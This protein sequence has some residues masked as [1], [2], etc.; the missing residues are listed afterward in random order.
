MGKAGARRRGSPRTIELVG[1]DGFE[2]KYPKQL[3]GGMRMRA[4]LAR[5]LVMDPTIF[6]FDEP[7]GALDEIT[8]ERLNDELLAL[9][10]RK[11]FGA[12][13][14][15]HSIYRGRVPVDA[16]ARDVGPPGPH[17][18]QLRRAVRVP[19]L[20]RPALRRRASPRCPARSA[21]P[22]GE[23]THDHRAPPRPGPRVDA[24]GRSTP[25]PPPSIGAAPI[26][27]MARPIRW[28][29][30]HRRPA[31]RARRVRRAVGLHAPR[32]ML[33]HFFDKPGF[34]CPSPTTVIDRSCVLDSPTCAATSLQGPRRWTA[35]S[36]F[37]SAWR[38]SIV[39]GITIAVLM[40]QAALGR[41]LAVPVP[42]RPAGDPDPRH[43]A[44]HRVSIFGG[45]IGLPDPRLRDDLDLPDRL[46]HAVRAARRSTRS[47]HD[48][49]T[50]KG[51]RRAGRASASC[52]SRPPC[53]RSSP[54]SASRPA[55]SVIGA[56]VGELFF[57]AGRQPGIGIVM[58]QFRS[59]RPVPA[60]LRRRSFCRRLLGIAVFFLFGLAL[61]ARHRQVV[62][63]VPAR[64]LTTI[65]PPQRQPSH[66]GGT[67]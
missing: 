36:A 32:G 53:R 7:F 5:S 26:E 11:G 19:P 49:F 39:L 31:R 60:D 48:L 67:P 50:L 34:L 65:S 37:S 14:I 52:S 10:Q 66:P 27:A 2:D 46:E 15:T 56:V 54:A 8:R 18:R 57:R 51:V 35:A 55:S 33:E 40:A 45:G 17:R 4:S 23:R 6:L 20:A 16:G 22:C 21:T 30:R 3:S 63:A 58:D 59:P 9:F 24:A 1:L 25:W 62:R 43:R 28:S 29:R 42:G 47:Q 41:A 38:I 44:D 13:F 61:Q 12:L 64:R